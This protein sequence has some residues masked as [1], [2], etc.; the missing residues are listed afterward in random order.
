MLLKLYY[1]L[2]YII[3]RCTSLVVTCCDINCR[4]INQQTPA[5]KCFAAIFFPLFPDIVI[6]E[7]LRRPD[8][9]NFPVWQLIIV[10]K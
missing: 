3:L 9:L 2:W 10:V 4:F 7:H 1:S 5:E 6:S 8:R